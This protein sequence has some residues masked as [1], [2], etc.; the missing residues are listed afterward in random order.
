[1]RD[2]FGFGQ[3]SSGVLT[4]P[5]ITITGQVPSAGPTTS[6]L[7]ISGSAGAIGMAVGVR[8]LGWA[9]GGPLGALIGAGIGYGVAKALKV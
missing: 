7:A 8:F 6:E 1:M 3:D 2:H 9:L 5:E 4:L